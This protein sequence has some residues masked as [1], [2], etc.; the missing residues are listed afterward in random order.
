MAAMEESGGVPSLSVTVGGHEASREGAVEERAQHLGMDEG[1]G[2]K[3]GTAAADA[4]S[5]G[6]GAR[7]RG[8]GQGGPGFSAAW[9]GKRGRER[10]PDAVGDSSAGRWAR[11]APLPRDR[12][13][14]RARVTRARAANRRDRASSGLSGNDG[15]RERVREWGSA[16]RGADRWARQHSATWFGFK[17]IQTESKIFQTD[18]KFFKF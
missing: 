11:A 2:A 18:S 13:G 10:G 7:H 5:G 16:A 3:R 17:P 1:D 4:L 15:V 6:P 14:R 12:G 8:K 9:R